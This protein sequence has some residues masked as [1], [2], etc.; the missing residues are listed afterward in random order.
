MPEPDLSA[1]II[2][3]DLGGVHVKA[4]LVVNRETRAAVQV[5]C[6]LWRGLDALDESFASLPD[7]ARGG[8]RHAVTM[9]GELCDCFESRREG[10][11]ALAAWSAARLPGSVS[12]YGGRAGFFAP[13]GAADAAVEVASAN[14]HASAAW[15]GR[16]LPEAVL[17]DVGSTTTDLIPVAGGEPVASGYTD[18][19]RL[20]TGELVYTGAIRT[21]VM[22]LV[23]RVPFDGRLVALM[24]EHFATAADVHRLLGALPPDADQQ[25]AADGGDKSIAQ[26]ET[27]LA[28]MIGRDRDDAA[29]EQ[30]AGLAAFLAEAQLRRLHDAA[31][32]VFSRGIVTGGAP[33][34]GCG[35]GRFIAARLAVRLGRP[36][37]DL[38][39]LL[40]P[41]RGRDAGLLAEAPGSSDWISS[42]APAVCVALLLSE[43]PDQE[44]ALSNLALSASSPAR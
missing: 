28:R 21:P 7:W 35:V 20:G 39:D 25:P 26:T 13:S 19:E 23:D 1:P 9:T 12:I 22:A 5:P 16:R 14:W 10:V 24:A 17:V 34:V 32:Q 33:M 4:A 29:P 11:R 41:R 42:C 15:L 40:A 27:R 30:W 2:G 18:A 36:Y 37:L 44:P 3:W 31:A 43:R 6:A 8:G 38:A